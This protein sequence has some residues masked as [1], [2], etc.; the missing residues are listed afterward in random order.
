MCGHSSR[1]EYL[2][3]PAWKQSSYTSNQNI[4]VKVLDFVK[5]GAPPLTIYDT[6]L[7]SFNSPTVVVQP[8]SYHAATTDVD[9][10]SQC[11]WAKQRG[12]IPGLAAPQG[13]GRVTTGGGGRRGWSRRTWCLGGHRLTCKGELCLD[14]IS[15]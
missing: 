12:R 11:G 5:S 13:Q 1:I 9:V 7:L 8:G 6:I 3:I 2:T 4:N 10:D 15:W 14:L